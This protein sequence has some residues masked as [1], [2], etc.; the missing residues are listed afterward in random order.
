VLAL[1]AAAALLALALRR[2]DTA[3]RAAMVA[4]ALHAGWDFSLRIPAM[5][6]AAAATMGLGYSVYAA[7]ATSRTDAR[8]FPAVAP[9]GNAVFRR[10]ARWVLPL[11]ILT[12]AGRAGAA[13]GAS[14][15]G[16]AG[17]IVPWDFDAGMQSVARGH[18]L[19]G[20]VFLFA[21]RFDAAGSVVLD[22]RQSRWPEAV[23]K[24][25]QSGARVW[26]T[27]VNDRVAT[28]APGPVLKDADLVHDLIA[29][30][31]RAAAHRDEI[32]ALATHLGVDGVD[33]DY[34][35]L[36]ATDRDPFTAFVRM[37]AETLHARGL[38]LSATVQPKTGSNS[39]RGPGAMDWTALC[40][41]A[42]RIQI[43][44]YNQHNASTGPGA[45]AGLDWIGR[46][47]DYGLTQC[48]AKSIVPVL[49]VSGM[50]WGSTRA[51]WVSFGE[52]Q[53]LEARV[54]PKVRR[55]RTDRVPWFS[56]RADG[57][58]RTVYFEDAESLAAKSELLK[59][60][61]LSR[62]VLWSLGSED[63]DAPARI[64]VAPA[65]T[66]RQNR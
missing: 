61:G 15:S 6:V 19:Y 49:K 48:P 12:F 17:W 58:R 54:R 13:P 40:A 63:P 34:E 39:A 64:A 59:G 66:P 51:D 16:L 3:S 7:A 62:L 20:D 56:Y 4:V 45:I 32:V 53:S 43:M 44:L 1:L 2:G 55:D 57:D 38:L 47:A 46:V 29:S 42:D 23:E 65:A 10:L 27:V 52:V 25:R 11:F 18:G 30:R 21:A 60:R 50:D 5:A 14:S 31:E 22:A 37:L 9:E 41:S 28:G 26:L 24:A 36:P 33:L 35:N 8:A